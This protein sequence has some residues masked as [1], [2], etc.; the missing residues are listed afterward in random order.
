MNQKSS[1]LKTG[2]VRPALQRRSLKTQQ[3]ILK[4]VENLLREGKFE[5][6]TVQDIV[7][8]SRCSIGAFYGRFKDKNAALFSFYDAH[9]AQLESTT[10]AILDVNRPGGDSL[11][12]ILTEFV[13][14]TVRHTL[15]HAAILKADTIKFSNEEDDPFLDRARK[16]NQQLYQALAAVLLA[17]RDEFDHPNDRLSAMFVLGIVGG[18]TRDA[19]TTGQKLMETTA[20]AEMLQN[21]LTRTVLGYLGVKVRQD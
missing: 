18:L 21:E 6:A 10:L 2:P 19:I 11:A 16:M 4:V 20:S 5:R 7:R 3:K 8:R 15:A 12:R 14:A 17:R 13:E 9:C 1:Q